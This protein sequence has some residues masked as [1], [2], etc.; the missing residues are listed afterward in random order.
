MLSQVLSLLRY[1]L[2]H[3]LLGP[4][5]GSLEAFVVFFF[6]YSGCL[7]FLIGGTEGSFDFCLLSWYST[8]VLES[9]YLTVYH[10]ILLDFLGRWSYHLKIILLSFLLLLFILHTSFSSFDAVATTPETCWTR[11]TSV[12]SFQTEWKYFERSLEA[13]WLRKFNFL[14]SLLRFL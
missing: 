8:N 4:F 7:F 6:F 10:F 12:Y 1:C 11:Q 3:I 9:Y 13:V 14:P 2:V 5:L